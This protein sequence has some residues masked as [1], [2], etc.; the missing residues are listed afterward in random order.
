[1]GA[2]TPTPHNPLPPVT[3]RAR[4]LDSRLKGSRFGRLGFFNVEGFEVWSPGNFLKS[5]G[6]EFGRVCSIQDR[7]V[8]DFVAW[9]TL[10]LHDH[11]SLILYSFPKPSISLFN[12]LS[13][14]AFPDPGSPGPYFLDLAIASML[15]GSRFGCLGFL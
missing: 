3:V 4:V 13:N 1:M 15:N 5:K 7:R 11:I 8:R 12:P 14:R 9:A 10:T 6:S 2:P